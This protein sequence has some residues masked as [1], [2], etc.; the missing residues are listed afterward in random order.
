[1]YVVVFIA[2]ITIIIIIIVIS[3]NIVTVIIIIILLVS[4]WLSLVLLL[5]VVIRCAAGRGVE[6]GPKARA[7][8]QGLSAEPKRGVG[9]PYFPSIVVHSHFH[10][11]T[12]YSFPYFPSI[13][14]HFYACFNTT[15]PFWVAPRLPL[16][17]Q[18]PGPR[19]QW[20]Q[21]CD[22]QRRRQRCAA[23][24]VWNETASSRRDCRVAPRPFLVL[25]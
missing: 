8:R 14:I 17:G 16:E 7:G 1:M 6:A 23:T 2:N 11:S 25:S 12:V 5:C 9:K 21:G 20:L 10:V 19:G 18:S 15:P 4:L 13:V 22:G 3:V 24:R